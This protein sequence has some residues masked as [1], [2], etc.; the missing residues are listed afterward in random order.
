MLFRA[1]S[2]LFEAIL[3][4]PLRLELSQRIYTQ[5]ALTLILLAV[6]TATLGTLILTVGFSQPLILI[7]IVAMLFIFAMSGVFVFSTGRETVRE[8]EATVHDLDVSRQES[9]AARAQMARLMEKSEG[10]VVRDTY[11]LQFRLVWALGVSGDFL[12]VF[13]RPDA[14]VGFFLVDVE[15]HGMA[16]ALQAQAVSQALR[17]DPKV[18]T[19]SPRIE[20]E[21]ADRGIADELENVG[22]VMSFTEIDPER[23]VLRYANAGMPPPLLFRDRRSQPDP[24]H[25]AG[26]YV[27]LGYVRYPV[28]PATVEMKLGPGDLLV[29]FSDGITEARDFQG[30]IFGQHGVIAAVSRARRGSPERII[31]ELLR[32]VRDHTLLENPEDDQAIV[33]VRIGKQ[34]EGAARPPTFRK[35]YA[36]ESTLALDVANA[37]DTPS[38]TN[39]SLRLAVKEWLRAQGVREEVIRML[40]VATLEAILNA[41]KHG[42]KAGDIIRITVV[43][44][45]SNVE[46]VVT[47]PQPWP[48]ADVVLARERK[49]DLQHKISSGLGGTIIMM[50]LASEV[51]VSNRGRTVTMRFSVT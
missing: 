19:R 29:A 49:P 38:A 5:V 15:G 27:G 47:Q 1:L 30:R 42:S 39:E 12:Q 10:S 21:A 32:A 17:R 41:L 18:G 44:S 50:R 28:E 6:V 26:V 25:A 24:L 46:V 43:N 9:A 16:A 13:P 35:V 2:D 8:A 37:T 14:T 4:F 36:T 33:I 22:V 45:A 48:K 31:E 7:P 3:E 34:A 11:E 40:W 23:M 20:L 51:S